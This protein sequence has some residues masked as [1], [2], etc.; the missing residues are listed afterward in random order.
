MPVATFRARPDSGPAMAR[1]WAERLAPQLQRARMAAG[2]RTLRTVGER[3]DDWL[4]AKWPGA[5]PLPLPPACPFANDR[6]TRN[7]EAHDE[8]PRHRHAEIRRP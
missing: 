6:A 2:I 7:P 3:P 8:S 5:A 4:A 1:R